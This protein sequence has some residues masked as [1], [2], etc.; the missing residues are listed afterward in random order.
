MRGRRMGM[1]LLATMDR[2]EE[3]RRE[4]H[5]RRQVSAE[6]AGEQEIVELGREG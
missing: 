1:G 2:E 5:Q 3:L 6:K 4:Y